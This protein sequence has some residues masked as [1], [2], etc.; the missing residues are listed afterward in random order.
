[1]SAGAGRRTDH[2]KVFLREPSYAEYLPMYGQYK[3]D[4]A[5]VD[6]LLASGRT[7]RRAVVAWLDAVQQASRGAMALNYMHSYTSGPDAAAVKD[8]AIHQDNW[9]SG[10]D[11]GVGSL[12]RCLG[13]PGGGYLGFEVASADGC[14]RKRFLVHVSD[15]QMLAMMP[16]VA[17]EGYSPFFGGVTGEVQHFRSACA[18]PPEAPQEHVKANGVLPL[19]TTGGIT[20]QIDARDDAAVVAAA[21][22]GEAG[23]LLERLA[24]QLASARLATATQA[25]ASPAPAQPAPPSTASPAGSSRFARMADSVTVHPEET[26][27]GVEADLPAPPP[28]SH[29]RNKRLCTAAPLPDMPALATA[30]FGP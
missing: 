22:R 15:A 29:P 9:G 28:Q 26:E 8:A 24:T 16:Q 1:M 12:L 20:L 17:C 7:E 23:S 11:V 14:I 5:A 27:F 2:S 21:A 25:A 30:M 19:A 18:T 3:G 6:Q 4:S 13:K 10:H